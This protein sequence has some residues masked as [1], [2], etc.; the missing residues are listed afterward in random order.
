[1]ATQ[2]FVSLDTVYLQYMHNRFAQAAQGVQFT[3]QEFGSAMTNLFDYEPEIEIEDEPCGEFCVPDTSLE[4]DESV[5]Q[6]REA[7][8]SFSR[9]PKEAVRL[10]YTKSVPQIRAI[11][12]SFRLRYAMCLGEYLRTE[13][14]SFH[15][16]EY[17]QALIELQR[18]GVVTK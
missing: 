13:L 18:A 5:N 15:R 10:L 12:E 1:M 11:D 14:A 2:S 4:A 3:S 8:E 17:R 9:N 7:L 16:T 6:L